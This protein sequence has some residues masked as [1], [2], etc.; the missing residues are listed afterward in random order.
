MALVLKDRV[1][2]TSTTTGTGALTLLGPASGFQAFSTIGTGNTTHYAIYDAA[3]GAWE[4][5]I[6]TYTS[7]TNTL[8]RDTVLSSSNAGA[9]VNFGAGAKDVFCTMPSERAVYVDGTSIANN[10]GA[11]VPNTLLANS[12]V[13]INGNSVSLGGSTTVTATAT[14]ALT[15]GTGLSGTSYNGSAP[16]TVAIDAT[17]ATLTGSQTL[18]N[19]TISADNNTLSG[20]AASS[21]VLSNASGN[22]DGAAA[23]KA[24]PTGVVVGDTDTQT[25]TNK[26]ISADSNTLSGIAASS[27][28]LSNASGNIDGAAVQKAIPTGV[29]V[30][31]SDTQTLTNKTVALGSNTVSGT[32][33]QFNTAC[34]DADF[35]SLAGSET[36]TNKTISADNNTLSGIAASSFVLSN[37]SGNIDGAAAQK[38]I[39]TGVVV[40]TT[41]TQTLTN[42][43]IVAASNTITTAASGTL[44]A[45][46]LNAAL[47]ELASEKVQQTG[48]TGSAILPTGTTAQRDGSPAAGYFRFNTTNT[49]FEGY[50][51]TAWA[52]VGGA[53]GGG[54]NPFVYEND[55]TVTV[56]YTLTSG[57]NGVTAGPITVND[58]ITVTVPSGSVWTIV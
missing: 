19:K 5:G 10:A 11:T 44:A 9:L 14:N 58:G 21:F 18:T 56:D 8:S 42:K 49:A 38:A 25:L 29:V 3:T 15:I 1:R 27:F 7:G 45:T 32:L 16:V 22:I 48:T 55:Q 23:Q 40:G 53:S 34:T 30:G 6:G 36:L 41:D 57:K 50:N 37:A 52:G 12:S 54:G 33:A 47:A 51:G 26:T 28:V 31:D 43:T 4:V 35:A 17:V 46:E 39:P 24:I 13:T 20:I 2:E